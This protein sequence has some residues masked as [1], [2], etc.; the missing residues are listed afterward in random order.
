L[1]DATVPDLCGFEPEFRARC[2]TVRPPRAA[3]L[4]ELGMARA[5]RGQH[6]PL[7]ELQPLYLRDFVPTTRKR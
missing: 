5:A 7:A 2:S 6:T 3:A 4:L 1:V